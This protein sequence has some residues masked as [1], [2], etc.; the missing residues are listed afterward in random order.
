MKRI[1]VRVS[2]WDDDANQPVVFAEF[3]TIWNLSIDPIRLQQPH[4]FNQEGRFASFDTTDGR[5]GDASFNWFEDITE[6]DEHGLAIRTLLRGVSTKLFE[7]FEAVG[8]RERRLFAGYLVQD[9]ISYSRIYK[10]M[11]GPTEGIDVYNVRLLDYMS[12]FIRANQSESIELTRG[13]IYLPD[14]LKELFG[15]I[16]HAD[17]YP[18]NIFQFEYQV[19]PYPDY[20]T[21]VQSVKVKEWREGDH[22]L[23]R[24]DVVDG[25]VQATIYHWTRKINMGGGGASATAQFS[26]G[27]YIYQIHGS[28]AIEI[29]SKTNNTGVMPVVGGVIAIPEWYDQVQVEIDYNIDETE[30]LNHMQVEISGATYMLSRTTH[31]IALFVQGIVTITNL[32]IDIASDKTQGASKLEFINY[33]LNV[34]LASVY[35][36]PE[37]NVITFGNRLTNPAVEMQ[38]VDG[39]FFDIMF[40]GRLSAPEFENPFTFIREGDMLA[41]ALNKYLATE[42][43][44][45]N[46]PQTVSFLSDA[47]LQIGGRYKVGY[48][49]YDR[50]FYIISKEFDFD[51]QLYRYEGIR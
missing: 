46:R 2:K 15:D 30:W 20:G 7:I 48:L 24:L 14:K 45:E 35:Q 49:D 11:G 40:D 19:A 27:Y 51:R 41:K 1:F 37:S 50:D 22:R 13:D 29:F 42:I 36:D 38:N 43:I 26:Y 39:E 25:M 12:L 6:R 10:Q 32:F 28:S 33:M 18:F 47:N 9:S 5:F 21:S 4:F 31:L 23:G 8:R 16:G 17:T 44:A 3:D 34:L